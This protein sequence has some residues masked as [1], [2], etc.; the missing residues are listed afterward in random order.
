MLVVALNFLGRPAEALEIS[1]AIVGETPVERGPVAAALGFDPY[2]FALAIRAYLRVL[3]RRSPEGE[4]DV[5]RALALALEQPSAELVGLVHWMG[6]TIAQL[7]GDPAAAMRHARQALA[8]VGRI[9]LPSLETVTFGMLGGAH[10]V[11]EE[12]SEAT[13]A[14]ERAL[15]LLREHRVNV[16]F[17]ALYL[18]GLADAHLGRDEAERARTLAEEAIA[19]AGRSGGFFWEVLGYLSLARAHLRAAG[20]GARGEIEA[21]LAQAETL[22]DRG[23]AA[24]EP[25]VCLLR[26]ELAQLLG[27]EAARR[28]EL[29]EAHRLFL[30]M[31]AAGP[32]DRVKKELG[33]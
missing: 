28:R 21:A 4:G 6:A 30:E 10:L 18:S 9:H 2:P 3:V 26:A 19:G 11:R 14:F 25:R 20:A 12:W 5:E 24:Y 1:E 7:R 32:A 17:E 13:A 33:A 23:A 29:S 16:G 8:I 15:A 31:G 27:D 22:V